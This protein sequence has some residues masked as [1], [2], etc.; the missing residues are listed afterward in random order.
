M[1]KCEMRNQSR[2]LSCETVKIFIVY[3]LGKSNHSLAKPLP[4]NIKKSFYSLHFYRFT[5]LLCSPE[6]KFG[7]SCDVA[8]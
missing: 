5:G 2:Y 3:N 6:K 1:M 8:Q 7:S 4:P